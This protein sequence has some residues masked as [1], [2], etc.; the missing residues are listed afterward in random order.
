M[1]HCVEGTVGIPKIT[2]VMASAFLEGVDGA[3]L[4]KLDVLEVGAGDVCGHG[5][6]GGGDNSR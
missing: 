5:E 6:Q 2:E 3:Y 1:V 4:C